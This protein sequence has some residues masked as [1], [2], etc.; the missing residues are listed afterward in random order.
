M[1]RGAR[2]FSRLAEAAAEPYD[3]GVVPFAY[4]WPTEPTITSERTVTPATIGNESNLT[5]SGRRLILQAG[6]Y[7]A[8]TVSGN[9]R[10]IVFESG[11]TTGTISIAGVRMVFR[12]S[13]ERAQ[14]L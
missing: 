12:G 6:T 8:F 1:R 4:S 14:G 11:V 13:P 2:V 10:E 9:D 3:L 7:G 5:T